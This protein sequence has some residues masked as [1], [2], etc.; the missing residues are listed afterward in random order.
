M[1]IVSI[2]QLKFNFK[3]DLGFDR[4][5]IVAVEIAGEVRRNLETLKKELIK[6][7]D[8]VS[9]SASVA[10]PVSWE[11][12][13]RVLP[14]GASEDESMNMNAYGIDY[15]FIEL[16]GLTLL[17]GR[18]FSPRFEER[19][20]FIVNETT[21][22]QLNW[23]NP[24]GKQLTVGDQRG[25]VIGVVK[26]FHFKSLYFTG[27]TPSVLYIDSENVNYMYVNYSFPDRFSGVLAN[28]KEQWRIFA[29]DLP[30]EYVLLNDY[31]EDVYRSGDKTAQMSALIGGIA[32]FLSCLGLFGLSSYAVERR[33]KEIG[34]RKVLG[35]SVPSIIRM[36][37]KEFIIL[38]VIANI[39]AIPISYF[40]MQ[41]MI[42]FLY[43][44]PM[45]MGTMIF[46]LTAAIT[47]LIAFVTVILLTL[48]AAFANPI[49][50]L[51]YE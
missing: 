6:D 12:K 44:Y 42:Q 20:N 13:R 3:V 19:E 5:Q 49:D 25:T 8:I 31:F 50:S 22:R 39:I 1:T 18:S 51:R 26:D 37:V 27:M 36:L 46:I 7:K 29:P 23:E 21:V 14:E 15:D 10:M 4:S 45:N 11:T 47:M 38:I 40:L 41:S 16:I 35:A 9:V 48:K 24:L 30:F 2:K 28:I 32:I 43:A 17:Q 34:I 33:K